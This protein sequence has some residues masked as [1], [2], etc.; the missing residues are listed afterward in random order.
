[1]PFNCV[2]TASGH[3][4]TQTMEYCYKLNMLNLSAIQCSKKLGSFCTE[5]FLTGT[6]R[7]PLVFSIS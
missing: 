1:M 7:R 5:I 3:K 6:S 2:K 4:T